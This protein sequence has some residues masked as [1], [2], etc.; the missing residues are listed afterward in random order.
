MLIKKILLI[1]R[2]KFAGPAIVLLNFIKK[3]FY[4]VL[5][6]PKLLINQLV[7]YKLINNLLNLELLYYILVNI[8]KL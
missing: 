4:K 7:T 3:I 5:S 2:T 1:A 8:V 6:W